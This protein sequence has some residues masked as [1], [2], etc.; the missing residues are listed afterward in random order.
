MVLAVDSNV[1]RPM[2]QAKSVV[3]VALLLV[4]FR[5]LLVYN[6]NVLKNGKVPCASIDKSMK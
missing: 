1:T 5:R 6:G 3:D 2:W 4:T